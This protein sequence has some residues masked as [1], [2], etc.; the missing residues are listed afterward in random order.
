MVDVVEGPDSA[1]GRVRL[2]AGLFL[3]VISF[4]PLNVC[5]RAGAE[6]CPCPSEELL[7]SLASL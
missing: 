7:P 4:E 6:G 2:S 1:E 5:G 3:L